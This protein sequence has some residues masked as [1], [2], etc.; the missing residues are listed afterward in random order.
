MIDQQ[1]GGAKGARAGKIWESFCSDSQDGFRDGEKVGKESYQI[2][3]DSRTTEWQINTGNG[4]KKYSMNRTLMG[5]K[6]DW[7]FVNPQD[8]VSAEEID[9]VKRDKEN[10]PI[11]T[12]TNNGAT[13]YYEYFQE[14]TRKAAF[15]G[16][17]LAWV[18]TVY[19]DRSYVH[20]LEFLTPDYRPITL[21][22]SKPATI[23][24]K[25]GRAAIELSCRKNAKGQ[26]ACDTRKDELARQECL[27]GDFRK[28]TP[29]STEY[30]IS[31]ASAVRTL[32]AW[33][34]QLPDGPSVR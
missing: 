32:T 9:V 11:K 24:Y 25:E 7:A 20:E 10:R 2:R 21:K 17:K 29:S 27:F 5:E 18:E 8:V 16:S 13:V 28:V 12:K 1:R 34:E 4:T 6:K 23:S 31:Q 19:Q 15:M 33:F 30:Q 22:W 14:V 26:L 3:Y